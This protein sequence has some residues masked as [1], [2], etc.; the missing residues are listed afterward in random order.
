M[1]PWYK[2]CQPAWRKSPLDERSWRL[3]GTPP[4][5]FATS[6]IHLHW[7][8]DPVH[9]DCARLSLTAFHASVRHCM[10][11]AASI[12]GLSSDDPSDTTSPLAQGVEGNALHTD[13]K[14]NWHAEFNSS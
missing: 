13:S 2:C 4:D 14:R 10:L 1:Q 11:Q 12:K 6:E 8:K 9:A 5:C 7:T 3:T